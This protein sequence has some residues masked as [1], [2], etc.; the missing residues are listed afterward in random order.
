MPGGTDPPPGVF[1]GGGGIQTKEIKFSVPGKPQGKARA[2]TF[3][4]PSL[5]RMQSITPEQTVLYENL[6][7]LSYQRVAHGQ[8][9]DEGPL[10]VEIVAVF[11]P[12]KSASKKRKKSMLDGSIYPEV[13]PDIDNI[14]KTVLDALN[15]LAY[16]DDKSVVWL[17]AI[18][19]YGE[20]ERVLVRIAPS[21]TIQQR[22]DQMTGTGITAKR[23]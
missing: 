2:R 11:A 14:T 1:N 5:G 9:M 21:P 16:K 19:V 22:R 3:Y 18:K 6:I 8:M 4:N 13:K 17:S 12:P 23:E 15:G 7:K 10:D 20:E